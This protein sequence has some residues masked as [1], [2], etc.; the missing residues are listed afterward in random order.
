MSN[1]ISKEI[2]VTISVD[3]QHSEQCSNGCPFMTFSINSTIDCSLFENVSLSGN[4]R[5]KSC[6]ESFGV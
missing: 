6:I 4:R 2:K 3:D 1:T 5:C